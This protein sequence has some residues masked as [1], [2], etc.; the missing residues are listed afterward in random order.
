[1]VPG[2][3]G[4]E[5][6][7]SLTQP[8][9]KERKRKVPGT[10][11]TLQGCANCK[12]LPPTTPMHLQ[13]QH[14]NP[15]VRSVHSWSH[16]LSTILSDSTNPSTHESMRTQTTGACMFSKLISCLLHKIE[17]SIRKKTTSFMLYLDYLILGVEMVTGAQR[18]TRNTCWVYQ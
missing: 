2:A 11:Y 16:A 18:T 10:K 14:A 1:M 12:P 9:I 8:E 7:H 15:S 3:C 6:S 5:A 4:E 13:T 17:I